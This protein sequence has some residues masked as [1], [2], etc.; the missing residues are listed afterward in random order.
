[1]WNKQRFIC[2]G[3]F[4]MFLVS[5]LTEGYAQESKKFTTGAF[6]NVNRLDT[7]LQRGV[8]TKMDVQ[9]VLGAPKGMGGAIVPVYHLHREL[10]YYEDIEMK[11][12]KK[13]E[14]VFKVN[15][16]QQVLFITFDKGVYDGY[17]WF[18]NVSEDKAR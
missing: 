2:L 4:L 18:T 12:M 7:D 14:G 13:V 16:R 17:F 6:V 3:L 10:W 9:R 15:M 5:F 1:M 8:S 11:D